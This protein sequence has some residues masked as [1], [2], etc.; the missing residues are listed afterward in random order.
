MKHNAADKLDIKVPHVYSTPCCLPHYAES[1]RQNIIQGLAVLKP[2]LELACFF[3][4]L[5]IRKL[6]NLRLKRIYLLHNR[7][8]PFDLS[9][10]LRPNNLTHYPSKHR[11][12]I[13]KFTLS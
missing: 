4:K 9:F 2:F 11:F 1:L 13:S 6:L 12:S 8:Q 5:C 10:I 3:A 7:P